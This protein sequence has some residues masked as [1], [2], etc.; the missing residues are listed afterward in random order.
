LTEPLS[1]T[2]P[3]SIDN[4]A[5]RSNARA[6][7]IEDPVEDATNLPN[8]WRKASRTSASRAV[9]A[10]SSTGRV[11]LISRQPSR[12]STTSADISSR[13]MPAI[14]TSRT[15]GAHAAMNLARS[16]PAL[17]QVPLASLKS[18]AIRPSKSKPAS[19]SSSAAGL[20]ASPNL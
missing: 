3:R 7:R 12:S 2:S 15:S 16:G 14:T 6:I 13:L 5:S 20:I 11:G 4:G 9:T 1:V 17:T 10:I 8:R 19:R 18:S